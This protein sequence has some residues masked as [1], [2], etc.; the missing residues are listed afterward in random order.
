MTQASLGTIHQVE[1][2]T[3]IFSLSP[4]TKKKTY[5]LNCKKKT[6]SSNCKKK[7]YSSL[8]NSVT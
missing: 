3:T 5:S 7:T 1:L 2:Y 6:Y 8:C 4:N